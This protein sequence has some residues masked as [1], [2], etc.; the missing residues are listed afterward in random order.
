MTDSDGDGSIWQRL[1]RIDIV[2]GI[3]AGGLAVILSAV[4]VIGLVSGK[5]D[6]SVTGPPSVVDTIP[7]T[8]SVPTA[9][10]PTATAPPTANVTLL[11][12]ITDSV[13]DTSSTSA[14]AVATTIV[15]SGE[16]IFKFSIYPDWSRGKDKAEACP[17]PPTYEFTCLGVSNQ[18]IGD[19]GPIESGCH[20]S[21][22][23]YLD[24]SST[25]EEKG[26]V[27]CGET[28]WLHDQMESG[29]WRLDA[30]LELDDGTTGSA[31]YVFELLNE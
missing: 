18:V 20:L 16:P 4:A 26:R 7:A 27:S 5:D 2:V 28:I 11:P 19:G 17:N 6:Q 21:W 24:G 13:T 3:V 1:K 30:T 12:T 31:S 29:V 15:R 14:T 23:V 9:T 22:V 8:N 10:I 25:I